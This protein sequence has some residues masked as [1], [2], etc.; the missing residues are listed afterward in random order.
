[1]VFTDVNLEVFISPVNSGAAVNH[2]VTGGRERIP[3]RLNNGCQ[4]G[5]AGPPQQGLAEAAG[6]ARRRPGGAGIF[7][8]PPRLHR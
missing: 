7:L 2:S 3:A 4:R 1:M 6:A 5:G 8:H